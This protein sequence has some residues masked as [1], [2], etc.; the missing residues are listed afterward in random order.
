MLSKIKQW[1]WKKQ[2]KQRNVHLCKGAYSNTPFLWNT[3]IGENTRIS[4]NAYIRGAGRN[5]YGKKF[6]KKITIG[7]NCHIGYGTFIKP[8]ISIGDNSIIGA[9]SVVTKNVPNN[10]VWAGIPAK[11]IKNRKT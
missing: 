10:E 8:G 5:A 7:N 11:K 1:H 3:R 2:W 9:N 4:P 6:N